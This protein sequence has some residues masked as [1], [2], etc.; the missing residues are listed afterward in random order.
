MNNSTLI[1]FIVMAKIITVIGPSKLRLWGLLGMGMGMVVMT[2]WASAIT[3]RLQTLR[4]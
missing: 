2:M 4:A 3:K 1:N